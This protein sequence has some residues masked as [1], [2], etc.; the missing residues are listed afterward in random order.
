[1]TK[2]IV[3]F[4]GSGFIGSHLLRE[5]A[6]NTK[7]PIVSL[8]Q[9]PPLSKVPGVEYRLIDIRDLHDAVINA[10]ILRIYNLAAVHTTP[11]HE[12]WEYYQTNVVGALETVKFAR[13]HNCHQIH[14]VST[15]SVYGTGEEEK[16]EA[17]IPQPQS[18][19][20]RSKLMAERIFKDWR[21]EDNNNKLVISRPAVVFGPS[22]G[23]NFT[24][25]AKLLSLGIFVYPGRRD[26][27]KSCIFVEDLV[28]W[29]LHADEQNIPEIIF[30]GAYSERFSIEDIVSTFKRIAFPKI[31]ELTVPFGAL[32]FGAKLLKYTPVLGNF[33]VHPERVEKLYS[34][35]NIIP[36]W[37]ENQK[38]NTKGR[39]EYALLK[40]KQASDGNFT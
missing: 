20:G 8:D 23:G 17:S 29:M 36:T 37:A 6:K 5:I 25:L 28:K 24:R 7:N 31:I 22:E 15:M 30:N 40:W 32:K 11:G 38:L 27:I 14:F 26:T 3:V 13:Q 9:K 18:D 16:T 10:P 33:G 12:P 19:Y 4:G 1:M 35:T 2:K 34:S 39:L 21:Y